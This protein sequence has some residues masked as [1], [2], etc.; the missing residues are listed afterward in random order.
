MLRPNKQVSMI[1]QTMKYTII[2]RDVEGRLDYAC[3][4]KNKGQYTYRVF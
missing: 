3:S 4:Q 1:L 2:V